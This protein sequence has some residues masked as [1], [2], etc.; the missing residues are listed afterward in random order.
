[1]WVKKGNWSRFS[2][3]V[4]PAFK[5]ESTLPNTNSRGWLM[6]EFRMSKAL[7]ASDAAMQTK[8]APAARASWLPGNRA[9]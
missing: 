3:S 6:L 9:L 8:S 5:K 2:N 7:N 1:M 4:S